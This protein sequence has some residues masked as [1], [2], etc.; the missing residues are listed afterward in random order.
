MAMM[1]EKGAVEE[2]GGWL[3]SSAGGAGGEGS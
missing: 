2:D 1:A 3:L